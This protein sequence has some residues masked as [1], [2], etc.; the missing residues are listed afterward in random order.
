MNRIK[1]TRLF[2]FLKQKA[3]QKA[4]TK[5][6]IAT[7]IQYIVL[8][9]FICYFTYKGDPAFPNQPGADKQIIVYNR[10]A[11]ENNSTMASSFFVSN[12]GLFLTSS[13][14]PV[15]NFNTRQQFSNTAAI[16][17]HQ[18]RISI[19]WCLY[20]TLQPISTL[21]EETLNKFSLSALTIP[22]GLRLP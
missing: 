6:G 18:D 2:C 10:P 12:A 1:N 9:S 4:F 3:K 13:N 16:S 21:H 11:I 15:S 7:A 17:N 19:C 5:D 20:R 22:F 14:P 8:L